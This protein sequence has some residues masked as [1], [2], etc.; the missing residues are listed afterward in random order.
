MK[1]QILFSGKNKKNIINLSSAELA[2]RVVKVNKSSGTST[3]IEMATLETFQ[4]ACNVKTASHHI[5]V[6]AIL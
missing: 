3:F 5:S 2:K 6:S 1:C 4:W